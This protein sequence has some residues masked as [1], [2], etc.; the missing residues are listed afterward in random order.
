MARHDKFNFF[1]FEQMKLCF[2]IFCFF[3]SVFASAQV[4]DISNPTKLP[5]KTG[6]FK[7]IGKNNDGIVVRLYG[8]EDVINVYSDDLKLAASKTIEYKNQTGL[9]QHIML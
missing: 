7:I 9:L 2:S 6:K 4:A 1:S 5:L 3:L 8:T